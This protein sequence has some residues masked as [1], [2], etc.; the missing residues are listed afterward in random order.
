ME[1]LSGFLPRQTLAEI[2]ELGELTP[3]LTIADTGLF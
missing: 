3:A 2:K 1:L